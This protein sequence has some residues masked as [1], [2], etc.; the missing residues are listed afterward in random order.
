MFEQVF[1]SLP[2]GVATTPP[3]AALGALLEQV[4][5]RA[6][7][8]HDAVILAGAWRRQ[9]SHHEA[10]FALVAREVALADP[11]RPGGRREGYTEFSTDELRVVLSESRT[12]VSK[13]LGQA[14]TAIAAIPELWAAWDAGRIDTDRVRLCVTWTSSLSAEHARAVVLAVLPE[15][16]RLTL[17]GLVERLQQ[18]ATGLDPGWAAKLYDN[19][20]RQ[21][22][23]RARRTETGTVNLSG[24]DLPL[25]AG[26]LSTAHVETLALRAKAA[27]HPGLIDT[28]RA[29]IYLALLSPRP[30]GW[31]DDALVAHVVAHADP[32]DPRGRRAPQ[33]VGAHGP[34][35][36]GDT[37]P[38]D[39]DP[40]PGPG[41][42]Q[43]EPDEPEAGEPEAGEPEAGQPEA[44][45][46]EPDEPEAGQPEPDE[47]EAGEPE[48]GEPEAGEP[49]VAGPR[50]TMS[51]RARIEMRIGLLTLLGYDEKPGI[52]PGY[53]VIHSVFA[54]GFARQLCHAEWRVAVTDDH[55]H[56]LAALVTRRRPTGYRTTPERRRPAA[57]PVL[58]LHITEQELTRS[59]REPGMWAPVLD[60][61]RAQFRA[62]TGPPDSP[63]EAR[64][65]F[66]S[67]ALARW[68]RS[69]DR[70]CVFPPCRAS[71]LVTDID[72]TR[73]VTDRGQTLE[74]NLDPLCGHDH[75]LK[76]EGGW[77]LEQ[78]APGHFVWTSPT[79]HSYPRPPR[80]VTPDIPEPGR[81]RHR[82]STNPPELAGDAPL[83]TN[84]PYPAGPPAGRPTTRPP[85]RTTGRNEPEDDDPPPF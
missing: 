57:R 77:R 60:D 55:G 76:H 51:R 40:G 75:L 50:P 4:D 20:R 61:L 68:I 63:A 18:V 64:R 37:R 58:E 73:A 14:D 72:H 42:G 8:P 56:L 29:D 25:D 49:A 43:P 85:P 54:R 13:L 59:M 79:G 38:T 53:G 45:Q 35:P 83:W 66:P 26:A 71:S 6:V 32:T 1:A 9:L 2:E 48:A 28:V 74:D 3:G 11:D 17:S 19:A 65:R 52:M 16:P 69:R 46:P 15:A 34:R 67:A 82:S 27:G 36:G 81:Y 21:R 80:P 62:W 23:V 78:P 31:D 41:P 84:D 30:A 39:R 70:T 5:P 47:P 10:R 33:H 12:R 44:G 7:S 22:R 24:L